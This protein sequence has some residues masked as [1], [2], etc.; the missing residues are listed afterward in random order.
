MKQ[1]PVFFICAGEASG[2]VHGANLMKA[3]LS[4]NPNVQFIGVGG[5]RMRE[6]GMECFVNSEKLSVIGFVE[7]FKNLSFFIKTLKELVEK[8]KQYQVDAFIPIDF[9]DFNL[10]LTKKANAIGIKTIYYICPQVWAWRT[11]RVKDIEKYVDLLLPIFPF[12]EKYFD[13]NKLK[14]EYVGHPLLD[15]VEI[16]EDEKI[17][18]EGEG[19]LVIMPGSRHSEI[20]HHMPTLVEF[21][22]RF[23]SKYPKVKFNI[24][25]AHTLREEDL[26]KFLPSDAVKGFKES[27]VIHKH[28]ESSNVLKAGDAALIASGTSTLQGVLCN[29]PCSLFYKLNG[30]TYWLGTKIIKLSYVGLANLIVD[31]LVC[32][33]LLQESMNVDSLVLESELL[34]WNEA[35][36]KNM[37]SDYKMVRKKLGGKGASLRAAKKILESVK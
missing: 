9:P 20:D 35:K 34:L 15:E 37:Y 18:K 12:E 27:I 25:C 29:T 24:P 4:E 30:F 7:I 23:H 11:S 31:K 32:V 36:R 3:I 19:E 8:M 6:L 22:L 21:M 17:V 28:G 16:L 26:Y 14:V 10:R 2:D 33:E 13:T 5:P 1:G